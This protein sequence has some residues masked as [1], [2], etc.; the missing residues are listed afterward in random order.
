PTGFTSFLWCRFTAPGP[1]KRTVSGVAG[2]IRGA[3]RAHVRGNSGKRGIVDQAGGS[4]P[5]LR[6]GMMTEQAETG[7]AETGQAET[8]Q[9]GGG[10][11]ARVAAAQE[12]WAEALTDLGGRNTLLYYKDRRAGTLDLAAA[13]PEALDRL[14]R[15][16]TVRLTRLFHDVDARADAIRR[17][18]A[19]YRKARELAEER[20]LAASYLATGMARW[21]ELFLEPAAPVLLR[22]PTIVPAGARY[23]DFDLVLDETS[24]VN[25]VLLHKLAA[26]YGADT[27]GLAELAADPDQLWSA[28]QKVATAAEIPGFD[29]ADRRVIGTFTYAKLPLGPGLPRAG[30]L[31]AHHGVV[32]PI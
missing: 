16:G 27:D 6:E 17:M 23:D 3:L 15:S 28:L 19:I 31:L 13:A 2:G 24:E 29:I 5:V 7:Q 26:M 25:P 20:G 10:R 14:Q 11:A 1:R 9:A 8:G 18:Q 22:G 12:R 4:G 30:E 32:P 21:D